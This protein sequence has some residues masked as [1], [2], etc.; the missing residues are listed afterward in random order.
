MEV[1]AETYGGDVN[2]RITSDFEFFIQGDV[3][4]TA[5]TLLM[6]QA[7]EGRKAELEGM[8]VAELQEMA[9]GAGVPTSGNKAEL[10]ERLAE[11]E[12]VPA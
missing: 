5:A 6:A 11:L 7:T 1:P 10:V 8:T 4:R 3:T 2:T 12:P 9:S